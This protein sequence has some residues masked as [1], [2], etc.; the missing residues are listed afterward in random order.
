[1]KSPALT[2]LLTALFSAVGHADPKDAGGL[3]I[4]HLPKD[5][6]PPV[7]KAVSDADLKARQQNEKFGGFAKAGSEPKG[8]D[9]EK[10]SEFITFD[11][12]VTLVPKGAIIHVPERYRAN[13]VTELKGNIV[14]WTEFA[15]RYRAVVAPFEV[16]LAEASGK[17]AIKPE[18]LEAA[19]K[20]GVILIGTVG[21]NPISVHKKAPAAPATPPAATR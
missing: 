3:G 4:E 15:A 13:V 12:M 8:W 11:G 20:S 6:K 2:L 14:L 5:L 18:R 21:G 1:M 9:L 16:S 7:G 10:N 19:Q 17:E